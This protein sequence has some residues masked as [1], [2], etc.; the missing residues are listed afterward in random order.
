MVVGTSHGG[1]TFIHTEGLVEAAASHGPS[2]RILWWHF[3]PAPF[4]IYCATRAFPSLSVSLTFR[5]AKSYERPKMSEKS[6]LLQLETLRLVSFFSTFFLTCRSLILV[7]FFS[8]DEKNVMITQI[9]VIE[10]K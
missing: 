10:K 5:G 3:S 9:K 8:Y 2:Y 1:R 4:V 6:R 7:F